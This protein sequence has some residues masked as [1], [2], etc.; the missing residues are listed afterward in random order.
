MGI[1]LNRL[2]HDWKTPIGYLIAITEEYI[3]L[4][5]LYLFASAV[6][7]LECG[8]YFWVLECIKNV[9][10]DFSSLN[11]RAKSRS[12]HSETVKQLSVSIQSHARVKQLS[13]STLRFLVAKYNIWQV[14]CFNSFSSIQ[15]CSW[16]DGSVA[17]DAHSP[18]FMEYYNHM[19]CHA[20]WPNNNSSVYIITTFNPFNFSFRIFLWKNVVKRIVQFGGFDYSNLRNRSFICYRFWHLRNTGKN[21]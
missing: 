13:I 14:L 1:P 15:G 11:K 10:N 17:T 21:Q 8:F 2:P 4:V 12:N 20:N 3:A 6:L 7:S 16:S 18:I 19:Q 9:K 5:H